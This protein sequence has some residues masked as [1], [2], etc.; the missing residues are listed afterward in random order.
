MIP[1]GGGRGEH[2]LAALTRLYGALLVLYPEAFRRR[3]S[4]EMRQD[5][6][7]L[8]REGLQQ[9]G[10][11]ELVRVLAEAFSDLV[12]TALKERYTMFL[13]NAYLPVAPGTAA[14]WGALSALLGGLLGS[15]TFVPYF[16][17]YLTRGNVE[18]TETLTGQVASS[19]SPDALA[20]AM[21]LCVLGLFGLYGTLVVRSGR[22]DALVLS[23][24]TLAALS[25]VCI[26]ALYGDKIAGS[27]GWLWPRSSRRSAWALTRSGCCCWGRAPQ[28]TPVRAP[29]RPAAGRR[30]AAAGEHRPSHT[31]EQVRDGIPRRAYYRR[32]AL[33]RCG[34]LRVG[35]A[36]LL[37][38]RTSRSGR[39]RAG[40]CI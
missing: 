31:V 23:G 32:H 38:H 19:G 12:L 10:A 16:V 25:T 36:Q 40:Q 9:G 4:E 35:N 5:F 37:S 2:F 33:L 11:T 17:P 26:S 6:R 27:L 14:R 39:R 21:L 22:P 15:T 30:P 3:Y 29:A 1:R 8:L 34:A 20:L 28:G 18:A 7:E 24:A 13:R